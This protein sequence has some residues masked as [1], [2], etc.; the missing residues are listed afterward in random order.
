MRYVCPKCHRGGAG[1]KDKKYKCH[2]C[3]QDTM[4]PWSLYSKATAEK[5]GDQKCLEKEYGTGNVWA[6]AELQE[7]FEVVSF[8]APFVSVIRK[9][10]NMKGVVQFI[11]RPRFYFDFS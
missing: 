4:I 2:H 1:P 3:D 7:E 5:E 11:H 9:K 10:D 8:M 6:G